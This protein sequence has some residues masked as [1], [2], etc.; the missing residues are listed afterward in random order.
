MSTHA[1][2]QKMT[3][4]VSIFTT[5]ISSIIFVIGAMEI[6]QPNLYFKFRNKYINLVH[7]KFDY[8][9]GDVV[10]PTEVVRMRTSES[11]LSATS[12]YDGPMINPGDSLIFLKEEVWKVKSGINIHTLAFLHEYRKVYYTNTIKKSN[13]LFVPLRKQP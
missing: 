5:L 2:N 3:E 8:D 9:E 11:A 1:I 4:F 10:T 7:R 6:T 13:E 12:I